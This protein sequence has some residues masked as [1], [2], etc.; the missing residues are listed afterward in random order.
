MSEEIIAGFPRHVSPVMLNQRIIMGQIV[1]NAT[2]PAIGIHRGTTPVAAMEIVPT[3][4]TQ[5]AVIV[6]RPIIP[7]TPA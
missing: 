6:T 4:N 7:P 3:M 5:P 2:P 1:H